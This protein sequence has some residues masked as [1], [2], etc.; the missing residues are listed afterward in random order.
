MHKATISLFFVL[1]IFGLV[2]L[3][4]AGVVEGQKKFDDSYY[5]AK[6]QLLFGVLPGIVV[7]LAL[8]RFPY[9]RWKKF[10]LPILLVALGLLILVFVPSLNV[11]VKGAQRWIDVGV[12]TVQP[13][14]FLKFALVIY[15][16]AWFGKRKSSASELI[17]FFLI[18]GFIVALLVMQ[19]DFGTLG[20]VLMISIAMYFFSGAKLWHFLLL[21]L[22]L[23]V[24]LGGLAL[25]APYRFDRIKTFLD[26]QEDTQGASYHINQ[27]LISIGSG[28]VWGLGYGQSKQKFNYLPEPVGDSI[29]AVI[30]EELGLVGG[31]VLIGLFFAL[32]ISLAQTAKNTEDSFGRLFLL[33]VAVW[34]G[35]QAFINIAA[36][37]GLIPLTGVPLPLISYGSSSL[38]SLM[39]AMGIMK[40]IAHVDK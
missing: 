10:A 36:I 8:A 32:L 24:V 9:Q 12:A 6:H 1:I 29:F 40:N 4:S 11:H 27:A 35:G 17:P 7:F 38:V 23:G 28:G 33:G 19:P 21:L 30:V 39:A 13:S 2:M 37:S 31:L 34:I 18:L 25:A 14:E 22:V 5:Y 15:L 26:P 16:A 3:A 20:I